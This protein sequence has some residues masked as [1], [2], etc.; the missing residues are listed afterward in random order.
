MAQAE[1]TGLGVYGFS[2]EATDELAKAIATGDY[3]RIS[4]S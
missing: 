2:K 3:T 1:E 4:D